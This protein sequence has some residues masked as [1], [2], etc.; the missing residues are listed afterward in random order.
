A[1][2]RLLDDG[3]YAVVGTIEIFEEGD[4][5]AIRGG[6]ELRAEVVADGCAMVTFD[7]SYRDHED[8]R[9]IGELGTLFGTVPRESI[10]RATE[11]LS[12][13]TISASLTSLSPSIGLFARLDDDAPS[14]LRTTLHALMRRRREAGIEHLLV[15]QFTAHGARRPVLVQVIFTEP[16]DEAIGEF[17]DRGAPKLRA[18]M[19]RMLGLN[20]LLSRAVYTFADGSPQFMFGVASNGV[21]LPPSALRGM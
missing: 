18:G 7:K 1:E 16:T 5:I 8:Q 9:L 20:P 4:R 21:P 14:A 11:P 15:F 6:R 3:E 12:I 13:L 2:L 17:L 10:M 19:P